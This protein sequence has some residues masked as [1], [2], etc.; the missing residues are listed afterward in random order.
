AGGKM[1][2]VAGGN[3]GAATKGGETTLGINLKRYVQVTPQVRRMPVAI[4]MTIDQACIED[5][6]SHFVNS[7]LRFQPTQVRWQQDMRG[8]KPP[9]P[10]AP[11]EAGAGAVAG[12]AKPGAGKP[13]AGKPGAGRAGGPGGGA[14]MGSMMAQQN[15]MIGAMRGGGAGQ[16]PNMGQMM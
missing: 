9:D 1:G 16:G 8:I 14:G 7:R 6:V 12:A 15:Q 2:G 3:E 11:K 5:L 13:G 10:D 4:N